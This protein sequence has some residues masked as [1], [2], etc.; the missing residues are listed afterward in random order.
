[1]RNL[2]DSLFEPA[3]QVLSWIKVSLTEVGAVAARGYDLSVWMGWITVLGDGFALFVTSAIASLIF[4]TILY[5]I[6]TQSRIFIWFK[7]LIGR[8]L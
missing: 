3:F 1:M 5:N 4:L 8:W 6:K 7:E 2:I